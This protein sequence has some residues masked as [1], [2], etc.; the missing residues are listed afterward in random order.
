VHTARDHLK[1]SYAKV[2]VSRRHGLAAG[3][4]DREAARRQ[5][6]V[7]RWGSGVL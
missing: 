1:A 2:G 7:G 6:R 5:P 4:P 3:C